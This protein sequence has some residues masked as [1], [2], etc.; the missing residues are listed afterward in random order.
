M[1]V[2]SASLVLILG[3]VRASTLLHEVLLEHLFQLPLAF[4]NTTPTGRVMNRLGKDID[5]ID[6][7][8]PLTFQMCLTTWM[9]VI[10]IILVL[11]Y[12]TPLFLAALVPL[13]AVYVALQVKEIQALSDKFYL[14]FHLFNLYVVSPMV[15]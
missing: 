13:F 6:V 9:I 10:V 5:T 4:F 7:V 1:L 14:S 15:S 3:T 11:A 8:L 12:V 2:Y